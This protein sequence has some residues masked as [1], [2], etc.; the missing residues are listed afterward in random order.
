MARLQQLLA[1]SDERLDA[2]AWMVAVEVR[3]FG[4]AGGAKLVRGIFATLAAASMSIRPL[5]SIKNTGTLAAP[6]MLRPL[7]VK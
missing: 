1:T 3:N 6:L 5:P 7:I 2:R 4:V